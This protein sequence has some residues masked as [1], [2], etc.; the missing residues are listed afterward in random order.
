MVISLQAHRAIG[1]KRAMLA[2][3][4]LRSATLPVTQTEVFAAKST[5]NHRDPSQDD[6]DLIPDRPFRGRLLS[7]PTT[8]REIREVK[9]GSAPQK[10]IRP[11]ARPAK[12]TK[13]PTNK[14]AAKG[15]TTKKQVTARVDSGRLSVTRDAPGRRSVRAPPTKTDIRPAVSS[16]STRGSQSSLADGKNSDSKPFRRS[17][18]V[19]V[20]GTAGASVK[21]AAD[22]AN[23]LIDSRRRSSSKVGEAIRARAVA[24]VDSRRPP[25]DQVCVAAF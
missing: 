17:A 7:V 15:R 1:A 4:R 2:K 14:T 13:T 20:T 8:T 24:K 21:A 25:N 12:T 11:K 16:S 3:K 10:L 9:N 18:S 22:R 23:A 19:R 5:K 6:L